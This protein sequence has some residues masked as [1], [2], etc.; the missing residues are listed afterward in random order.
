MWILQG[1][2][3]KAKKINGLAPLPEEPRSE[4]LEKLLVV[5]PYKALA[6]KGKKTEVTEAMVSLRPRF[7]REIGPETLRP[8]PCRM[9]QGGEC[10]LALQEEGGI[11]GR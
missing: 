1:W 6:K 11:Q 7:I 4:Q 2:L 8:C 5:V 10:L 9:G 3:A